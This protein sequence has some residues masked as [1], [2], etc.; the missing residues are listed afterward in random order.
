MPGPG[1][2]LG[3]SFGTGIETPGS[4]GTLATIN[5]WL[6]VDSCE[7]KQSPNYYKGQGLHG[8]SLVRYDAE[9]VRT[10]LDS[11]GSVKLPVY[12][13]GM[14]R[15]LGSLMG[16][17]NLTPTQQGTTGTAYSVAHAFSNSWQQSISIQQGIPDVNQTVH[18]WNHLGVK[19]TDAQ[20]EC[21]AGNALL[22]TFNVDCQDTFEAASGVAPTNP[23]GSPYFAW[24]QMVVK[25]GAYGSET[26]VDGVSKWTG[27]IKRAQANKR[28]NA[29][30]ITTN[31]N[32]TY[33]VKSEPVDNGF[34]DITGTLETEYLN[35]TLFENYYQTDTPF[36][37]IVS[38]TSATVAY[39]GYPY[40][41]T[42]AF[43]RCRFLTGS[44]PTVNGPDIVKP[45]MPYEVML[46]GTHPAATIT[47]V[48][49]DATL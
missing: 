24:H 31:P 37:L 27:N 48:S 38:F 46:D 43:P 32:D 35:D 41:I 14:G 22:G 20:F 33:A 26:K 8:G 30:N 16:T 34:A 7:I 11:A 4:Y 40:S 49:Q 23:G 18:Y 3:S 25:V 10:H 5:K 15:L 28:F 47:V 45:S 21:T 6:P 36:S 39:T 17:L 42:F 19:V 13:N 9:V 1:S 44:N 12:Y 2:G 29:G